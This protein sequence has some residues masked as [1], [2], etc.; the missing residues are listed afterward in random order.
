MTHKGDRTS[1]AAPA[2]DPIAGLEAGSDRRSDSGSETGPGD[3][4]SG[5][6]EAT[7]GRGLTATATAAVA[8]C[9]VRELGRLQARGLK[10]GLYVVATPI[11]NLGDI[12]LRAL[13]TLAAADVIYCE[14]TRHS[15]ALTSHYSITA[16]LRSYH[17]HNAAGERPRIIRA[18]EDGKRLALISD[19]GTPL[20]SDPGYKLIREVA[21]AGLDVFALPGPCA[22][23]AALACA[24]LPTDSFFFAGFMSA[25][26]GARR[27]RLQALKDVPATLVF[28][29]SP[30]RLAAALSDIGAQLAGRDVVVARELTKLHEE[31]RRGTTEELLCWASENRI[32]G[33][34]VILV[35]PPGEA[36]VDDD[37]IMIRLRD[38]LTSLSLRDA[39]KEIAADLK[40][41]RRRVYDLGLA[42][43]RDSDE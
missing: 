20:I 13:A 34:I 3:A 8:Q 43:K 9:V 16:P 28:Y 17:E 15:R 33:E 2:G 19:A 26:S 40:V 10:P 27:S 25:K 6:Q 39:A 5:G 35:G 29:E 30:S 31:I 22:A 11:G 1:A 21:A 23:L 18:L 14:D 36:V 37:M 38:A 12:T 24:G 4:E 32:K 42:L 7:L 41:A